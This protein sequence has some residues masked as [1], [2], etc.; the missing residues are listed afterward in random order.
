MPTRNQPAMN[1]GALH[2]GNTSNNGASPD[3][4]TIKRLKALQLQNVAMPNKPTFGKAQG[5]A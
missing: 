3:N 5:K 1:G 2:K 4:V